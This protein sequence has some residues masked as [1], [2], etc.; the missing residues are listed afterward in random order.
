MTATNA[1]PTFH[2]GDGSE[3]DNQVAAPAETRTPNLHRAIKSLIE[4]CGRKGGDSGDSAETLRRDRRPPG[5]GIQF[6][7]PWLQF[8]QCLIRHHTKSAQRVVLRHSLLWA[9]VAEHVQLLLVL[10]T[11]TMNSPY[12]QWTKGLSKEQL[13]QQLDFYKKKYNQ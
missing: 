8:P 5:F 6:A 11:H 2:R 1:W 3:V 9:D 12:H 10:S 7:K 13:Q 4:E